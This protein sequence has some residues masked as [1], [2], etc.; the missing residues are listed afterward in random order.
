MLP[1]SCRTYKIGLVDPVVGEVTE[2]P[3]C[4][5]RIHLTRIINQRGVH[6]ISPLNSQWTLDT[7]IGKALHLRNAFR[8]HIET[9]YILLDRVPEMTRLEPRT[10]RVSTCT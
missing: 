1:V 8:T 9:L 7:R 10:R 5:W 2:G 6:Q 3:L 4:E